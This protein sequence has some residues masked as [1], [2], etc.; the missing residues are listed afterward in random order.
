TFQ[1][2]LDML[3]AKKVV[4]SFHV[5]LLDYRGQLQN[6]TSPSNL[7]ASLTEVVSAPASELHVLLQGP[8]SASGMN[9]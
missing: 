6:A 3:Q 1:A 8:E 4:E 7:L 9:A 5:M 2:T